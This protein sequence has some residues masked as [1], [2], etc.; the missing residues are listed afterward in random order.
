MGP[1]AELRMPE[2][3][4]G[5]ERRKKQKQSKKK[6]RAT[7]RMSSLRSSRRIVCILQLLTSGHPTRIEDS[8]NL[9]IDVG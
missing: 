3:H 5:Q 7:A 4:G 6:K 2:S 8:H 9:T 1:E